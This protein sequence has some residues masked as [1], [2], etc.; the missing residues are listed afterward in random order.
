[1]VL[2]NGTATAHLQRELR[3]KNEELKSQLSEAQFS[4]LNS[5][6]SIVYDD[7]AEA[8]EAARALTVP[9]DMV[10][11]SPGCASF[12]MFRNE[13]HRGEEFRRIVRELAIG[14]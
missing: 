1:V 10:L 3:M 5:Q 12:G 9:G 11:L 2:L 6:F 4:I 8:I 7:F 14:D 13:F